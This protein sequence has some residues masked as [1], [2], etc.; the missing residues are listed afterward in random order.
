M[1]EATQ[2]P[3]D[4]IL[5]QAEA[6]A[7]MQESIPLRTAKLQSLG[8]AMNPKTIGVKLGEGKGRT[9]YQ[10]AHGTVMKRENIPN[11]ERFLRIQKWVADEIARMKPKTKAYFRE[12][13]V[14]VQKE[15]QVRQNHFAK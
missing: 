9:G 10:S 15:R 4:D 5:D 14:I 11:T 12:M 6:I 3:I 1:P 13:L 2:N 8:E 7:R